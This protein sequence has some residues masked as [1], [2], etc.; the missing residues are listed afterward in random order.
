MPKRRGYLRRPS[1]ASAAAR[2]A[3]ETALPVCRSKTMTVPS[4]VRTHERPA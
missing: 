2:V 4:S 3:P 1:F